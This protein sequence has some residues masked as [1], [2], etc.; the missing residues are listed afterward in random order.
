MQSQ[1]KIFEDLSRLASGAAGTLAGMSREFEAMMRERMREFVGGLDLVRRDEFEA[2]RDMAANA[3]EEV[4]RLRAEIAALRGEAPVTAPAPA[5]ATA[6]PEV[7][8][9]PPAE[10][11]PTAELAHRRADGG[12][13]ANKDETEAHPS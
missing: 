8:S 5:P 4:E 13:P 9:S 1:N 12:E 10:L 11:D 2:V 6:A 7:E 3:R